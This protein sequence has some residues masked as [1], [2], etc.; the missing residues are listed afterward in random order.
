MIV[1]TWSATATPQGGG[2][3]RRYFEGALI[4]QLHELD[5]FA[6]A[7]LLSRAHDAGTAGTVELTTHTF[8][9]SEAAIRAFAGD[10]PGPS[11]VEPEAR[12]CLLSFDTVATHRELWVDRSA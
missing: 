1:R 3:Y 2:A 10:D 11:V 7:Y 5:G 9:E 8:W 4:P 6:G 12:A